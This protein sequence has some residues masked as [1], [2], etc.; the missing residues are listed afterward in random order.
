MGGQVLA[1][2][3]EVYESVWSVLCARE[4]QPGHC[5]VRGVVMGLAGVQ[6]IQAVPAALPGSRY[7]HYTGRLL[8]L[9]LLHA[10]AI[11]LVSYAA[12]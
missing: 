11:L 5:D 1:G 3:D 9:A 8:V 12:Q 2:P 10:G 6:R 4:Y 7:F